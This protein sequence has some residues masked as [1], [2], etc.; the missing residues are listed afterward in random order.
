MFR[1]YGGDADVDRVMRGMC[2]SSGALEKV[3]YSIHRFVM[4]ERVHVLDESTLGFTLSKK[5]VGSYNLSLVADVD[6]NSYAENYGLR[7]KDIICRITTTGR[8][9]HNIH[10]W[11][12]DRMKKI[13]NHNRVRHLGGNRG[14]GGSSIKPFV[15][16]VVRMHKIREGE[17]SLAQTL[18][19]TDIQDS[20]EKTNSQ[21]TE[22]QPTNGT[23][24]PPKQNQGTSAAAQVEQVVDLTEDDDVLEMMPPARFTEQLHL[25]EE[26]STK[27][28]HGRAAGQVMNPAMKVAIPNRDVPNFDSAAMNHSLSEEPAAKRKHLST[29]NE[30]AAANASCHLEKQPQ[31][32]NKPSSA[33]PEEYRQQCQ[34]STTQDNDMQKISGEARDRHEIA[35]HELGT[36]TSVAPSKNKRRGINSEEFDRPAKLRD[37]NSQLTVEANQKAMRSSTLSKQPGNSPRPAV[38]LP[39]GTPSTVDTNDQSGDKGGRQ[40]QKTVAPNDDNMQNSD[41]A[42]ELHPTKLAQQLLPHMSADPNKKLQSGDKVSLHHFS[43]PVGQQHSKSIGHNNDSKSGN[44]DTNYHRS[45]PAEQQPPPTF[46]LH[47]NPNPDPPNHGLKDLSNTA[48]HRQAEPRQQKQQQEEQQQQ[49]TNNAM[50]NRIHKIGTKVSKYFMDEELGKACPFSGRISSYDPDSKLYMIVYE[51]GDAEELS[52][53]EVEMIR[54]RDDKKKVKNKS[55]PKDEALPLLTGKMTYSNQGGVRRHVLRGTWVEA[56]S[57][58]QSFELLRDLSPDEDLKAMPMSGVFHGSFVFEYQAGMSKLK[59]SDI[60]KEKNVKISFFQKEGGDGNTYSVKARGSNRFGL[61]KLSGTATKNAD[62]QSS[63][64]V[65][66]RKKYVTLNSTVYSP[67]KEDT[68]EDGKLP[69]PSK[70]YPTGVLCLR[71]QLTR[72]RMI[73]HSYDDSRMVQ[74]IRGV[75]APSLETILTDSDNANMLCNEFRYQLEYAAGDYERCAIA[76]SDYATHPPRSGQF[77]GWFHLDGKKIRELELSINFRNNSEGGFNIDGVGMNEFGNYKITGSMTLDGNVVTMFRHYFRQEVS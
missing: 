15:F 60:V 31:T 51:D 22:L 16:E 38:T 37:E 32:K 29:M 53:D 8:V 33:N 23:R 68:G 7:R 40:P 14:E 43:E 12:H 1:K 57:S 35:E 55:K 58:P 52:E 73:K 25:P 54:V 20:H 34:I 13:S 19:A 39:N 24:H 5:L 49:W 18:N 71:G 11:F 59:M 65:R 36:T 41:D 64:D 9:L 4:S 45:E 66:L 74:I 3:H 77:K 6:Q 10:E 17:M 61:F 62:D 75:W 63:F 50:P 70:T 69:P 21:R 72:S 56:D 46:F 30:V 28:P 2:R 48:Q 76:P 27:E 47:R 42:E 44:K 26:E 67:S